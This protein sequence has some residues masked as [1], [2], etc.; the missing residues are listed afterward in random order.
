M[1]CTVFINFNLQFITVPDPA[2]GE[3][4]TDHAF[5]FKSSHQ[6]MMFRP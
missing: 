4:A 1:T 3:I 2:R 5:L 6:Y